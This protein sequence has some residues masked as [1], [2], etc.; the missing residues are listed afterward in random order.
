MVGFS[1]QALST[2]LVLILS[3]IAS[4]SS[5]P[6]QFTIRRP[7]G[8]NLPFSSNQV[9]TCQTQLPSLDM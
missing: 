2:D 9:A 4:D 1:T 8:I 7:L 5:M 3:F 6:P